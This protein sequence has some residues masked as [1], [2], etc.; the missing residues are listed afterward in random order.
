MY[1]TSSIYKVFQNWKFFSSMIYYLSHLDNFWVTLI[2]HGLEIIKWQP[3]P[4]KSKNRLIIKS[5]SFSH[6]FK[7]IH[8]IL[9]EFTIFTRLEIDL[10]YM[11]YNSW[12][13]IIIRESLENYLL[14]KHCNNVIVLN[15]REPKEV[16]IHILTTTQNTL[17]CHSGPTNRTLKFSV[18]DFH[19][20]PRG[21]VLAW[22]FICF[23]FLTT[24]TSR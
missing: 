7:W 11:Q 16:A 12:G 1:N 22:Y 5:Q 15:Y 24:K 4:V 19:E 17:K 6:K 8:T 3:H 9:I 18:Q 2:Y 14:N 21:T 20:I 13:F 10:M 23:F